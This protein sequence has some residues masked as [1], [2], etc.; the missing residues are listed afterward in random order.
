MTELNKSLEMMPALRADLENVLEMPANQQYAKPAPNLGRHLL[1]EF[2]ECTPNVLNNNALVEQLMTEAAV[3]C[4]ATIVQSCF[5]HFN[6]YG[7]SGVIVIAE[8]HLTIHTWPEYG[9][10][11]VD[12]YTCGDQ[13]DPALAFNYLQDKFEAHESNYIEFARGLMNAKTGKMMRHPAQQVGSPNIRQ[14]S[15]DPQHPLRSAKAG[16][17]SSKA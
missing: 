4:G 17:N 10:A 7:V 11:S 13:C 2:F 8:S 5:H 6:P 15:F 16:A 14:R 1:A 9:Y 3:A 12:L